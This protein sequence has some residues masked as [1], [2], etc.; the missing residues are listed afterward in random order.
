MHEIIKRMSERLAAQSSRRG[1]L[2]TMAKVVLGAASALAAGQSFF[3]QTAEAQQLQCC[4]GT[5]CRNNYC[6]PGTHVTYTWCCPPN[7]STCPPP[8]GG[9]Y[10]H[11]CANN[12]GHHVCT[13]VTS[14]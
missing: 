6:P 1:F 12:G 11:D 7:N 10:C 4:T 3:P 13:Y 2:S 8:S 5:A 14:T 9:Y